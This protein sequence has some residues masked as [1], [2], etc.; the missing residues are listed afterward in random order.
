MMDFAE[1]V[2]TNGLTLQSIVGSRTWTQGQNQ[3]ASVSE[4][5]SLQLSMNLQE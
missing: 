1:L 4:D 3:L 5:P 2:K